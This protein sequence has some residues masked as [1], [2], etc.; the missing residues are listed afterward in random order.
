MA[1]SAER[2][3]GYAHRKARKEWKVLVEA[4]GVSCAR[5]SQP[6]EP[7]TPWDL[8]HTEDRTGYLGASHS[9]C[10]RATL[11]H[12]KEQVTGSYEWFH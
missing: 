9:R 3:Y 8:D 10:N 7:G 1:T 5:C 11:T 12:A 2:G 4:G 6:I